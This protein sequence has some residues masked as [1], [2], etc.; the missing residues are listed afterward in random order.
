MLQSQWQPECVISVDKDS[1]HH[2]GEQM[3]NAVNRLHCKYS[4][5]SIDDLSCDNTP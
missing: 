4:H 2:Q 5:Y 3:Q 1:K